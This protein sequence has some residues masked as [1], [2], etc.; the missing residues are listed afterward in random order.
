MKPRLLIQSDKDLGLFV[1]CVSALWA[2]LSLHLPFSLTEEE[3][4]LSVWAY[5]SDEVKQLLKHFAFLIS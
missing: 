5:G 4:V 3:C 2:T 1:R